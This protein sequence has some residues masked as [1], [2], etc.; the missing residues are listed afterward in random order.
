MMLNRLAAYLSQLT[1]WGGAVLQSRAAILLLV[2]LTGGA[3][4]LIAGRDCDHSMSGLWRLGCAE[5]DVAIFVQSPEVYTRARLLNDR[6]DQKNWLTDQLKGT[7]ETDKFV[8]REEE[9]RR[10]LNESLKI[11]LPTASRDAA[12]LPNDSPQ[13]SPNINQTSNAG[14]AAQDT[15]KSIFERRPTNLL[16][17]TIN[18]HRNEIRSELSR[19]QLDDRHD[20]G[21]NTA[22]TLRFPTSIIGDLSAG[23]MGVVL[24]K[25]ELPP[26]SLDKVEPALESWRRS[27]QSVYSSSLRDSAFSLSSSGEQS[28]EELGLSSSDFREYVVQKLLCRH[29]EEFCPP[30]ERNL[31]KEQYPNTRT[32]ATRDGRSLMPD[33]EKPDDKEQKKRSQ[34]IESA[35]AE[36]RNFL[37]IYLQ[38]ID[39]LNG[40]V[41]EWAYYKRRTAVEVNRKKMAPTP[42]ATAL[43]QCFTSPEIG[44][45]PDARNLPPGHP[46]DVIISNEFQVKYLYRLEGKEWQVQH[47]C[48]RTDRSATWIAKAVFRLVEASNFGDRRREQEVGPQV[49]LKELVRLLTGDLDEKAKSCKAILTREIEYDSAA[50]T[51]L[52][53]NGDAS[54]RL[55]NICKSLISAPPDIAPPEPDLRRV[56]NG[57]W[58]TSRLQELRCAMADFRA[59]QATWRRY[60]SPDGQQISFSDFF[61]VIAVRLGNQGCDLEVR[62]K[63]RGD[64]FRNPEIEDCGG[65][66]WKGGTPYVQAL[67]RL[68]VELEHH[69]TLFAL[70]LTPPILKTNVNNKVGQTRKVGGHADASSNLGALSFDTERTNSRVSKDTVATV[71]SFVPHKPDPGTGSSANSLS[72]GS[73]K[74]AV[75]SS[76]S[77]PVAPDNPKLAINSNA[78][79]FGWAFLP[80]ASSP[81]ARQIDLSATL[82]VPGWVTEL[83]VTVRSCFGT[84]RE[85]A[86]VMYD[87][88][89]A[90]GDQCKEAWVGQIRLPGDPAEITRKLNL[91]VFNAP[92]LKVIPGI[93]DFNAAGIVL[94][95][96]HPGRLLIPGRRLWKNTYVSLGEQLADEISIL[97][98]MEGIVAHFKCVHVPNEIVR[99]I[100]QRGDGS[101]AEAVK[102][103]ALVWTSEGVTLPIAVTIEQFG[104]LKLCEAQDPPPKATKPNQDAAGSQPQP[105]PQQQPQQ[106]TGRREG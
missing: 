81:G 55:P 61:D 80:D 50:R 84:P 22:Y 20:I 42:F 69:H 14:P 70:G 77:V 105:Q 59:Y 40:L 89:G 2:L 34:E 28:L 49:P 101:N 17:K 88:R 44:A 7:K 74:P 106:Q 79:V 92:Y 18:E 5:P 45:L 4:V 82:S 94:R 60:L 71:V 19:I 51:A 104:P 25:A 30:H 102:K 47:P 33:Y 98:D 91:E 86:D 72:Q 58:A 13:A 85:L 16:F 96:G 41:E 95:A 52:R 78:T 76:A 27:V 24:V 100:D 15:D 29:L 21:G 9:A 54:A 99:L 8:I 64:R 87:I 56:S 62:V 53:G 1:T 65:Q 68:K 97:P 75:G 12:P 31:H 66:T 46:R 32:M 93:N 11:Q 6:N 73:M 48:T 83:V 26:V 3:I 39:E 90:T 38:R 36:I 10:S 57:R 103:L 67:C 63:F 35:A 43:A 37:P 23:R